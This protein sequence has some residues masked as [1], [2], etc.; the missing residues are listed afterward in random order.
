M[1]KNEFK[2][3]VKEY[4]KERWGYLEYKYVYIEVDEWAMG[5]L[6]SCV[7]IVNTAFVYKVFIDSDYD[8]TC[9][10][11]VESKVLGL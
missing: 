2:K 3:M 9:I 4:I 6:A 10:E 5:Y 11:K 8:K 1:K 7:I